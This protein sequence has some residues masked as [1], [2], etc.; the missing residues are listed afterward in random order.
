[1]NAVDLVQRLH[2]HRA[3]VNGNLLT[4]AADLSD[5]QLRSPFQIGQA[6]VKVGA[7]VGVAFASD[8]STTWRELLAQADTRLLVAKWGGK[9]RQVG[10]GP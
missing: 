5:E 1:M 3:W 4:T 7:S 6:S 8:T 9:G 2:Q 10:E